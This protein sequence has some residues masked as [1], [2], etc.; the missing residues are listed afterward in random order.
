MNEW[1]QSPLGFLLDIFILNDI[2]NIALFFITPMV[3][4]D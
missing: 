3:W 4:F 1:N 2:N